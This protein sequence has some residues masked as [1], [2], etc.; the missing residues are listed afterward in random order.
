MFLPCLHNHNMTNGS[1]ER[2]IV[3]WSDNRQNMISRWNI[4]DRHDSIELRVGP[5]P[6]E[7][8]SLGGSIGH[9]SLELFIDGTELVEREG[10]IQEEVTELESVRQFHGGIDL[11]DSIT[12][13]G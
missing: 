5:V 6:Q 4:G 9:E 7:I 3:L 13:I 1:S 8:E 12:N 11:D 2:L 10:R